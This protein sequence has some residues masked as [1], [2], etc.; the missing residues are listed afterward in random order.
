MWQ[1]AVVTATRTS[2]SQ[3]FDILGASRRTT[4]FFV[5][6]PPHLIYVRA[7][8]VCLIPCD[9]CSH[10]CVTALCCSARALLTSP[11][12][13]GKASRTSNSTPQPRAPPAELAGDV[14]GGESEV[15]SG[16]PSAADRQSAASGGY[17]TSVKYHLEAL[18]DFADF[19]GDF[20]GVDS[21]IATC[22]VRGLGRVRGPRRVGMHVQRAAPRSCRAC[23]VCD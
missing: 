11:A 8:S 17:S 21:R 23:T 19:A 18:G 7:L 10:G 2:T 14:A 20:G 1:R 12:L 6:A 22:V 16:P 5:T 4:D 3:T 13:R 15:G 9:C